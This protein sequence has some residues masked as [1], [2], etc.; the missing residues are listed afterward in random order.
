MKHVKKLAVVLIL[1]CLMG[2]AVS[3]TAA[4]PTSGFRV[5]ASTAGADFPIRLNFSLIAAGDAEIS[6]IRLQYRVERTSFT[7]VTSE[8]MAEF[9]PGTQVQASYTLDMRRVGGLPPG[10]AV[11]YW[12]LVTDAR[13]RL[14]TTEPGRVT[15]DDARYSWRS[16]S[17]GQLT[18]YW[19]Q[20]SESFARQLM[21]A[22]Q[23]ALPR[24]SQ[25][26]GTLLTEPVAIYIYNGSRDLQGAMIFPNEWTGGVAYPDYSTITLGVSPVNLNWGIRTIAHELAHL[27]VHRLTYNP[28]LDVPVWL[29]EGMAMYAEGPLDGQFLS[30]LDQA[31]VADRLFSVRSLASPFSAFTDQSVLSYAQSYSIVEFLISRYGQAR[32]LELLGVFR[33]G[34]DYDDALERVYGFDMDGLNQLWRDYVRRQ[35][36]PP[37]VWQPEA[38]LASTA[39][40]FELS[41]AGR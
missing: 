2:V 28:Y 7:L 11:Q 41:G 10:T 6:D 15:W 20:G 13:G 33:Q 27:V 32:L 18:V 5:L 29:D 24:L 34:S 31:V 25:E 38:A 4:E 26:G 8:A 9:E 17:E 36:L 23:A 40:D 19:Y 39:V 12:W 30:A 14:I 35:Y 3:P 1:V 21:A 22:A 16:L 37:A